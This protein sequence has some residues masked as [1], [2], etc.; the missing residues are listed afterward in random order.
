MKIALAIYTSAEIKKETGFLIDFSD[1]LEEYFLK[2]KYGNDLIDIIIGVICVSPIF[3]HFFKIRRP[4]YTKEKKEINSEG[5]EYIIEKCLE[6]DIKLDFD[7]FKNYSEIETKKYLAK[8]IINSLSVF[9]L[10]KSK[11]KNFDSE[12]FKQDLESYFR[13]KGLII[14]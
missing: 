1:D 14:D 4:I 6:Y 13:E 7:I 3:E 5:F 9:D 2:K 8:E 11:I 12:K 10:M